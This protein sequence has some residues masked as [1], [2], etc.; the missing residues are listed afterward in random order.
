MFTF[1]IGA[2]EAVMNMRE[3]KSFNDSLRSLTP[4]EQADRIKIREDR[5]EKER[6]HL[7]ALEVARAGRSQIKITNYRY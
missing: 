7:R 2:I 6:E 3:E 4:A 1:P 5:K